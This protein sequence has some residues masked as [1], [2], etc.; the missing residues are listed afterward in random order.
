MTIESTGWTRNIR[1]SNW[2]KYEYYGSHNGRNA[3]K[4][5]DYERYLYWSPLNTWMVSILN[6]NINLSTKSRAKLHDLKSNV[7]DNKE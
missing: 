3:Y 1:T 6:G 2:G 7:S 4:H 5:I